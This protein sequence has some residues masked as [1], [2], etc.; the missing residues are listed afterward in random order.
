MADV[1][2]FMSLLTVFVL[3]CFVGYTN[4]PSRLAVDASSLYARNLLNFITPLIDKQT[5]DLKIDLEDEIIKGTLITRE[6][7]VVHPQLQ[8][9][10]A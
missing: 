7:Q 3:A 10:K 6:G 4:V 8:P 9:S 5:K 1:Y 2:S